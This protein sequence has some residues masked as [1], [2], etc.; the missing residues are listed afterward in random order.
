MTDTRF[1]MEKMTWREVESRL[2]DPT[3][4]VIVPIAST[5]Q[6]GP[7]LPLSTDAIIGEELSC[8]IA[9]QLDNALVAP[10]VR[11]G[12]SPF[13]RDFAG[14]LSIPAKCL[15]SLLR[16]LVFSLEQHGAAHI[17]LL[18]SHGGNFPPIN[19]LAPELAQEL[20]SANLHTLA[21][22]ERYM[23]LMNEGLQNAGIEYEEAVIH[24]G[25]TE[26]AIMLA[27]APSLVRED[28]IEPRYEGDISMGG[29]LEKGF[30]PYTASG[31]LGDPTHATAAAGEK[32]LETMTNAYVAQLNEEF[33][34]LSKS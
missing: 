10:T 18:P 6:H 29:L 4:V 31:V 3:A 11:P 15:M 24:A 17:V 34:E 7:H 16:H 21:D 26:T 22:L 32:I 19:T 27:V 1:Q 23:E 25:A 14:S 5:E 8:R 20:E 33:A 9:H 13:H 12:V 2:A 28:E 30:Q